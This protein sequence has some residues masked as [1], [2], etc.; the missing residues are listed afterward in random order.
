MTR[1]RRRQ[2]Y[3]EPMDKAFVGPTDRGWA[4]FLRERQYVAEVNFWRPTPVSFKGLQRGE[5]FLFKS[6]WADGN[7]LVGGGLFNH[8]RVLTVSEAWA[9]FGEGNGVASEAELLSKISAYRA[10]NKN[11]VLPGEDPEIGCILLDS[12]F[13]VE[14][15]LAFPA[16][17]DFAPN[18]T[19]GRS[20]EMHGSYVER[21]FA[22]LLDRSGGLRLGDSGTGLPTIVEG[23]MFFDNPREVRARRGQRA[24]KAAVTTAYYRRCAITG[25][26]LLPT[27]E[28]AHIRPVAEDGENRVDNG[29][30]LKSD[31]HTLFDLGYIG[32]DSEYRL[33]VSPALKRET[34]DGD[35][36]YAKAGETI[37]VM[38]TI[39]AD[40]PDPEA[41][42]WHMDVR[43]RAA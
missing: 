19:T 2:H 32:V 21:A 23:P 37:E 3:A 15:E 36:F 11:P 14:P 6:K 8:Y 17:P 29:L 18:L 39:A 1:E 7:Q 26:R 10:R 12:V 22:E 24:F 16:P 13:F 35:L 33:R 30:L 38:P 40:R 41:L 4:A 5:P 28:A 34:G 42:A 31:A 43:F 20:Y 27:L 25:S 9:F